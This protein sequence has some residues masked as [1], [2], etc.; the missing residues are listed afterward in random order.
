MAGAGIARR[1]PCG[2]LLHTAAGSPAGRHRSVE[3]QETCRPAG[4]G[5]RIPRAAPV[6]EIR[7]RPFRRSWPV[8]RRQSRSQ[9]LDVHRRPVLRVRAA[10]DAGECG[11]AAVV[12]LRQRVRRAR[13]T[14]AGPHRYH[15]G[16]YG[17]AS[18]A[19]S[20]GVA[21]YVGPLWKI[22]DADAKNMAA[23][24]YEAL[25]IRR[26]S[27]GEALALA[28][29]SVSEGNRISTSS[30]SRSQSGSAPTPPRRAARDGPAWC[31]TAI[32]RRPCFNA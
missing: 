7:H 9:L 24:F 26:T 17:M 10:A 27:L 19:L 22:S 3:L 31:C 18:A 12:D 16:V 21:A 29:R 8:R 23:A 32:P 6:A 1:I 15:D 4:D 25:L 11:S 5:G 2:R 30:S 14:E 13:A 28:R 20:Q